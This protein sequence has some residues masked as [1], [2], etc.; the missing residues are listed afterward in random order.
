MKYLFSLFCPGVLFGLFAF[1]LLIYRNV[2]IFISQVSDMGSVMAAVLEYLT[3]A[4]Y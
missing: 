1:L 3:H 4:G 2:I